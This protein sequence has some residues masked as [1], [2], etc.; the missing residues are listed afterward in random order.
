MHK[1]S[2]LVAAI[3]SMMAVSACT[4]TTGR[5]FDRPTSATLKIGETTRA[6]AIGLY[7][8]SRSQ[9]SFSLPITT[10]SPTAFDAADETGIV[11]VASYSYIISRAPIL[12]DNPDTV[13]PKVTP[14]RTMTLFFW[15]DRVAGFRGSSTFREDKTEFDESKISLIEKGKTSVAQLTALIGK[16]AGQMAYPLVRNKGNEKLIYSY[17]SFKRDTRVFQMKTLEVLTNAQ[18]VV[19]DYKFASNSEQLA[20]PAPAPVSIPIFI[21]KGK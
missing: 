19:V 12:G 13:D 4:T 17:S 10:S 20:M 7:G 18:N 14:A 9:S 8:E 21:P 15:N 5:Q 6:Q 2:L 11:S 1:I 16:P 3:V